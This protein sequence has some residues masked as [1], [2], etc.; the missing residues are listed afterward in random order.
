MLGKPSSLTSNHMTQENNQTIK[1]FL[2][3]YPSSRDFDMCPP[4]ALPLTGISCLFPNIVFTG[5]SVTG[6]AV[7][8]VNN[9]D[10]MLSL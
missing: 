3:E 8:R 10:T 1:T 9:G 6:M 5:S 4:M 2:T 7:G